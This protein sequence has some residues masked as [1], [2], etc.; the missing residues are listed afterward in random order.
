MK[1][2]E[3]GHFAAEFPH[4]K[5]NHIKVVGFFFMSIPPIGP[6]P[7][8]RTKAP[9]AGRRKRVS[10]APGAD[11]GLCRTTPP[12]ETTSG[13]SPRAPVWRKTLPFP[14]WHSPHET[15]FIQK[16][17]KHNICIIKSD[18]L[19]FLYE[20]KDQHQ[21]QCGNYPLVL[22]YDRSFFCSRHHQDEIG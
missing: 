10:C 13:H 22:S 15:P 12:I 18:H 17:V 19:F 20:Y 8:R 11:F 1:T 2:D 9:P 4:T 7:N 5:A 6:S 16:M 14:L 3:G 21:A